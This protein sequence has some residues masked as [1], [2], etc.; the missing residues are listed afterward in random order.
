MKLNI[1]LRHQTL[2]I[3]LGATLVFSCKN[4]TEKKE[5]IPSDEPVAAAVKESGEWI[6]LF[7]GTST[8][9]WRGYNMDSLPP[10]WIVKDSTLTFDTELGLEQNYTGGKDI[11]YA[12]QEF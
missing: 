6:Y 5:T 12:D 7:D 8:E 1:I 2:L 3:L 11:I 4:K 9:G 10:G